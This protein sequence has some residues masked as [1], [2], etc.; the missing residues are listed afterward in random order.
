MEKKKARQKDEKTNLK[1]GFFPAA[2]MGSLES[3]S[4]NELRQLV[5]EEV[6]GVIAVTG[7]PSVSEP[8]QIAALAGLASSK[9]DRTPLSDSSKGGKPKDTN[10]VAYQPQIT[11]GFS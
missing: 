4:S 2:E 7:G 11:V 3:Q 1:E 9:R 5:G 8:E 6:G 10:V